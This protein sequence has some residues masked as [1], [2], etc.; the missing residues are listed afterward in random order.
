M[1]GDAMSASA[2][3]VYVG[4]RY[5][6]SDDEIS[7]LELRRDPR[8]RA[9]KQVGL[10]SYWGNFGGSEDRYLLL[11]GT[12]IAVLGPEDR[13][14]SSVTIERLQDIV[15]GTEEALDEAGLEGP[16]GLHVEWLDD[17]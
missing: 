8:Q 2:C 3:I 15:S 10:N 4:I 12:E 16:R 13:S 14:W 7:A 5:E 6:V 1:R 9:A 17:A 11:V